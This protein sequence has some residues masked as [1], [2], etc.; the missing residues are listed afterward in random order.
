KKPIPIQFQ[1]RNPP[2]AIE[3]EFVNAALDQSTVKDTD[4]FKVEKMIEGQNPQIKAGKQL[5]FNVLQNK[6]TVLWQFKDGFFEPPNTYRVTLAGGDPSSSAIMSGGQM[7]LKLDGE[8]D[9]SLPSG[10]DVEGGDFIFEI[11]LKGS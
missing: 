8:N 4:T 7:P 10:N 3:V 5:T 6:T 1:S 2:D 9:H 11:V